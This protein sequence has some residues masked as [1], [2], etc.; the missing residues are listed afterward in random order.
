MAQVDIVGHPCHLTSV[1]VVMGEVA[2]CR[3][4]QQPGN[5]SPDISAQVKLRSL[6]IEKHL[7]MSQHEAEW[8]L[9][10]RVLSSDVSEKV[11]GEALREKLAH[12]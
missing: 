8:D 1:A 12:T 11:A 6:A 10:A 2:L 3:R 5:F 4:L 9:F 7:R